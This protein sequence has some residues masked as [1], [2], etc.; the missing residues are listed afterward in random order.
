VLILNAGQQLTASHSF[1]SQLRAVRWPVDVVELDADHG[2]I[3]GADY[4]PIAG[5]YAE[6]HDE[7][8][9]RAAGEVAALIIEIIESVP[10]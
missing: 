4:D 7:D 5:R 9:C 1:A 2:S 3:A 8:T 6:G 10:H